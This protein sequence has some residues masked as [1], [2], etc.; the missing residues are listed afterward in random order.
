[1]ETEE[2]EKRIKNESR[3]YESERKGFAR[4]INRE[5]ENEDIDGKKR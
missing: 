2:R 4:D 3:D 5:I 1:M